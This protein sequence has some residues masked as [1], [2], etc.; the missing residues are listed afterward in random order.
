[1]PRVRI[2]VCS[3][4]D[5]GLLERWYPRTVRTAETRLRYYAERF[6]VVEVDSPFYRLPAF[7]SLHAWI[8]KHNRA[9][10]FAMWNPQVSCR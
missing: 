4:A 1:M 10:T 8:W 7:Y 2:G 9:G 5:Q 6:D 3:W